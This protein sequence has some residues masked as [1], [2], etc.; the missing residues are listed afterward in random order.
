MWLA[1]VIC[2]LLLV[3]TTAF[4]K[5]GTMLPVWLELLLKGTAVLAFTIIVV[6][7]LLHLSKRFRPG[8][9]SKPLRIAAYITIAGYVMLFGLTLYVKLK[10]CDSNAVPHDSRWHCNVD[11]NG[12]VV[13]FVLIPIVA[14]I[15]GILAGGIRWIIRKQ[16]RP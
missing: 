14:A 2:L 1:S 10:T 4:I 11:G 3:V 16:K 13:Y 8:E 9:Q 7:P 12:V 5:P 6:S 15:I